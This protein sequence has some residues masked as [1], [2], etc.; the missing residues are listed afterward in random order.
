MGE[1]YGAYPGFFN[2]LKEAKRAAASWDNKTL[3]EG[4]VARQIWGKAGAE[5]WYVNPTIQWDN[6]TASSGQGISRRRDCAP[7]LTAQER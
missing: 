4:T 2:R 3:V 7:F 5:N 6:W 1:S